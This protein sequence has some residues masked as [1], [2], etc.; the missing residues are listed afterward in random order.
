MEQLRTILSEPVFQPVVLWSSPEHLDS[1]ASIGDSTY[2]HRLGAC[3]L[4]VCE[5]GVP[6]VSTTVDPEP[7]LPS[8]WLC[9]QV[10]VARAPIPFEPLEAVYVDTKVRCWTGQLVTPLWLFS[11][12]SPHPC[13]TDGYL[14]CLLVCGDSPKH[15]AT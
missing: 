3:P 13:T 2:N 7:L 15:L 12:V 9:S 1:S 11:E 6:M 8:Q 4:L 5:P 14:S 10:E